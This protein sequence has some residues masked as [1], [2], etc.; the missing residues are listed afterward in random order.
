MLM[1]FESTPSK[2]VSVRNMS[3][4]V[5]D[6]VKQLADEDIEWITV[7][8]QHIPIKEGQSKEEAIAAKFGGVKD[9][10]FN[11]IPQATDRPRIISVSDPKYTYGVKKGTKQFG[12]C[13]DTAGRWMLDNGNGVKDAK[14]VHGNV[15]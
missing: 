6:V 8:G 3:K 15:Y 1:P 7:N 14:L 13:F 11:L 4:L 2:D 9:S 12:K 5:N 10:S